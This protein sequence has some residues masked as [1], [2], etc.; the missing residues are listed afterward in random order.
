MKPLKLQVRNVIVHRDNS[1]IAAGNN[2]DGHVDSSQTPPPP[3]SVSFDL[4]SGEIIGIK[5]KTGVGK[6]RLLRRLAR[7]D[8]DRE[9]NSDCLLSP[10]NN[11]MSLNGINCSEMYAPKWRRDICLVS[12]DR[13]NFSIDS[14]ISTPRKFHQ[15]LL[16]LDTQQQEKLKHSQYQEEEHQL[17]SSPEQIASQWNLP[18]DAFDKSWSTLS[19]GEAQRAS[20]AIAMSLQPQVLLLDE[21]TSACD[22]ETTLKI[23]KSIKEYIYWASTVGEEGEEKKEEVMPQ[24][25]KIV[26]RKRR[27]RI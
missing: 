4:H 10:S 23:E 5:G 7:L 17:F 16:S 27:T 26:K 19:G 11:M 15:Y 9:E 14:N 20:L 22:E 25:R 3:L 8:Y 21:P 18:S 24:K 6:T 1:D 2:D 13:M 12:Q